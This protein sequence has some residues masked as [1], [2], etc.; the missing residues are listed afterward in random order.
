MEVSENFAFLKQEFPHAAESASYAERHVYG[1]PRASCFHARHALERLVKRVYKVEKTLSPPKVTNLDAYL[2]EPAFRAIV[3]EVVWQK[4]EYIRQAGNVAV[5]GN[6][7]P[8]PQQALNVVRE[9]AHVLYWAGRTY[10][11]KGAESLYGK[12]FDESLVPTLEP[13]AAQASVEELNAL[14]R[15]L[16][17]AEDARKDIEGELEALREQLVAIKAENETV[18]ETHDWNESATRRLIIDLALRRAG[19]P[20]DREHD[21][22]Y[23]VT[24]MPNAS[25]VGYADY[26]L[27]GDDGKPL[28]V[29]EA[30]KTTVDPAAGRQQAKLYADCL[31]AMRGQRPIIFYTNGY[32]TYLWDDVA[33][34]P[35]VV[36]GFYKKDELA[37][38]LHRR[39]QREP[40]DVTR[41]KNAIVERYYQKR[42]IGSIVEQFEL[43]RRKALLVMATGSGKTRVAVALVDLLQR[44]GW[45]KRALFLADRVSLVNQAVGAFKAHLPESSPVNLVTEKDKAG[46]VYVCTYPTMMGLINETTGTEARFGVGH[47]DLVII[48]EAHR[49]VYQ[50]YGAIF[51]YFDSLLVGLT[52]TPR[53]QVDR[54]TYA[55]FD[56]EPGVPTDAYE[57]ETAVADRFLV[58]PRVQQVDLKFPREGIEYD[59]LSEEEKEQW[60]SLDWGDDMEENGLPDKVNAGAINSWL[61]NKDTV[62]KVLQHLME[63]GHKVEGG[64]R[65][66][67]TIIFARN[68]KH[69]QFIEERFNHHY[70]QHKGHFARII[71]HYATYPQ[72]LLDDFS[73]KDKA[74]HI[75][76]S[77][78]MLDT[79]IDIPEVANLVFFKP[80]YSKIKFWQMIGRGTRLCPELFGPDDDKQ[81]FRVFDFCF[82]FDFFRENPAG[83]EERGIVPLGTR[84][85]RS[86]VQLLTHVQATPDLDPDTELAGALTTELHREVAAMN[87][88][89]FIVRMHL[90]AV[91]RFR[92]LTT[93]E[94]LSDADREVLQRDVAGLPSEVETDEIE[95]RMF[96][97]HSPSHAV[98]PG[99]GQ[100]GR[101]RE[102]SA[103]DGGNRHAA[104]GEEHDPRSEDPAR[105]PGFHAGE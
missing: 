20:L 15:R 104:G 30:K 79:G 81:D 84:L 57:L 80:V 22:E 64:D 49:S 96:D 86:R 37:S 69:A 100:H 7:T 65:L 77:V 92:D 41:I 89:N 23:E 5:H 51:R 71:D 93:W 28:A 9:L 83:I 55:L 39:A 4:A 70:P 8:T 35:R 36:A 67:K 45:V 99:R 26:V 43:K 42:A 74:P 2:S 24:G 75:A 68:H 72:S 98:S 18:P 47:F 88:E 21:R 38:L 33:Y 63:H 91:D 90:E 62:D 31:E 48:D 44:A 94:Q 56:L 78:D 60:E 19:W 82:N 101:R 14:K 3:P 1:D 40:L 58:P 32:E 66:A 10:L 17:A 97:P 87:R 61:F 16:D 103:A 52:A 102:S 29:V 95:S 27:W 73:Q 50:K 105:I 25:G 12:T 11:R 54:N 53:D 46:R 59:S 6:K 34:T 85:F 13:G 76:I